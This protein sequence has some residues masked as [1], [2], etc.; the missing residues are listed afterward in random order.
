VEAYAKEIGISV[1]ETESRI[2]PSLGYD[3]DAVG[4]AAQ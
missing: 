4:E 2:A 3:A 1:A